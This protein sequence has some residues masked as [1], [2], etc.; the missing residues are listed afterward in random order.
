VES[1]FKIAVK[2]DAFMRSHK[3]TVRAYRDWLQVKVNLDE[4]AQ[5]YKPISIWAQWD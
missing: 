5:I 4:L 1:L 2:L 3:L